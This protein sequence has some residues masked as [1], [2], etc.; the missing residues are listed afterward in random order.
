M[1]K[2][3]YIIPDYVDKTIFIISIDS[4]FLCGE[5]YDVLVMK[6]LCFIL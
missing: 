1:K 5:G 3:A 6:N 2:I 4:F